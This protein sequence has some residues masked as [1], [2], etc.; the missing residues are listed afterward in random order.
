MGV[1]YSAHDPVLRK[2][3]AIK[4]LKEGLPAS[5]MVRFQQEARAVG[6][7]KHSNIIDVYDFGI[8]E[9]TPYLVMEL[10]CGA[11][12]AEYMKS[13][14]WQ[15]IDL[16][17]V[18]DIF[19]QILKGLHHAHICGV[20]H[21]DIKPSNII[22]EPQ[23]DG[24]QKVLLVDFGLAKMADEDQNITSTGA[25]LGSPLYMSPEQV[26]AGE[27]TEKTDV[28]ALGCVMYETICGITPFKGNSAAETMM[29]HKKERPP[30]IDTETFN[31]A[32][33]PAAL[34][35]LIMRCLEKTPENRPS[36]ETIGRELE[37]IES[38]LRPQV[39]F[40]EPQRKVGSDYLNNKFLAGSAITIL[41]VLA[42]AG[43]ILFF[44]KASQKSIKEEHQNVERSIMLKA[45]DQTSSV[46]DAS[47]YTV[48]MRHEFRY[49]PSTRELK[50]TEDIEDSDLP[51]LKNDKRDFDKLLLRNTLVKGKSFW[52]L[53][54]LKIKL[55]DISHTKVRDTGLKY[56]AE[57]QTLENIDLK[58][59]SKISNRGIEYLTKLKS[60]K[61]L[62]VSNEFVDDNTLELIAKMEN[63]IE[64]SIQ[65]PSKVTARGLVHLENLKHLE[66]L[67]IA[68]IHLDKQDLKFLKKIPTLRILNVSNMG[69]N[70]E[71]M[72]FIAALPVQSLAIGGNKEITSKG[73]KQLKNLNK[74]YSLSFRGTRL[75]DDS[76][77]AILLL[78]PKAL[79]LGFTE[80]TEKGIEKLGKVGTIEE[81]NIGG[82]QLDDKALDTLQKMQ[83]KALNIQ[84][85][86]FT[87]AGLMKLAKIK[88]MESLDIK[89]NPN[90][91]NADRDN[92][93]IT[94]SGIE[95]FRK[96]LPSCSLHS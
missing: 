79:D 21:R 54:D 80:V 28:Y 8:S 75:D 52:A 62:G 22:L 18:I 86:K 25:A 40:D 1:V 61:K 2:N 38:S 92:P 12:L 85:N 16:P 83:I 58:D 26:S 53:K 87:D 93:G 15:T 66:S 10:L 57:S 31:G 67:N 94:N 29:M 63:L 36:M 3:V 89:G 82:L 46:L 47:T 50:A 23:E 5:V 13:E 37:S 55:L 70:D 49:D 90:K 65:A 96:T 11:S 4:V 14:T 91:P 56:L 51:T 68:G 76:L 45:A 59:C 78:K 30:N 81:L 73:F 71:D 6:K 42:I 33:I 44:T 34:P 7:L 35:P 32:E 60:L 77:G 88:S 24:S 17:T 20:L 64:L 27:I 84:Y 19:L 43:S 95:K 69:L 74:A 9:G 72:K 39:V 41:L 48:F